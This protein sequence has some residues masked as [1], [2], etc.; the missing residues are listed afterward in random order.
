MSPPRPKLA[1]RKSNG[2]TQAPVAPPRRRTLSPK[3]SGPGPLSSPTCAPCS[4]TSSYVIPDC[5][6]W[7]EQL[8]L[9]VKVDKRGS[10][11]VRYVLCVQTAA[12]SAGASWEIARALDQYRHFQKQ[13][14][15]AL[16]QGHFC[17][18]ECPWLYLFVKNYFPKPSL[19]TLA[20][21]AAVMET[22]RETLQRCLATL[23][24]FLSNSSNHCCSVITGPRRQS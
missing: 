21:R 24:S 5:L 19:L 8:E 2:T 6:L 1:L 20:T 17:R 13:L 9:T 12:G 3:A 18:A 7:L 23:Q 14:L 16:Q 10:S 11:D 22:R 4:T 15:K